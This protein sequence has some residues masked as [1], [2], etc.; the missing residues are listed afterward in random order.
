MFEHEIA[1]AARTTDLLREAAAYRIVGE[2]RKARRATLRGQEPRERVTG[3]G[4]RG[5]R[6]AP[7]PA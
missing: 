7:R 4:T 6:T 1:A 2:A 5:A 3:G